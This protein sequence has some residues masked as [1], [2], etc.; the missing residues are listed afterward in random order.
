MGGEPERDYHIQHGNKLKSENQ[1]FEIKTNWKKTGWR[2]LGA[3][4]PHWA[5]KQAGRWVRLF[6]LQGG[7]QAYVGGWKEQE[8]RS[9]A[10]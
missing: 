2:L 9:M 6:A 7:H 4:Q 3:V 5:S 1:W 10:H 8:R